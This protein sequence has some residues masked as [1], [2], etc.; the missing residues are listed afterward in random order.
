MK[1]VERNTTNKKKKNHYITLALNQLLGLYVL[2]LAN[3]V[4]L[5][6]LLCF[7]SVIQDQ[8][9]NPRSVQESKVY[10]CDLDTN[11]DLSRLCMLDM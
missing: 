5:W 8:N 10:A 11:L 3:H 2:G 6:V 1:D 4:K 7:K 9:K